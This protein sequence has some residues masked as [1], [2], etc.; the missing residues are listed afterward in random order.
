[1]QLSGL[2]SAIP[3]RRRH[4]PS[5]APG[6]EIGYWLSAITAQREP[7]R[8]VSLDKETPTRFVLS[9]FQKKEDLL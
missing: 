6:K 1:M 4:R 9:S 7:L 5:D 8:C 3:G 2:R